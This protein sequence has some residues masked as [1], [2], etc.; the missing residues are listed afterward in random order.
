MADRLIAG[1]AADA[2]SETPWWR[3]WWRRWW[4]QVLAVVLVARVVTTGILLFFASNQAENAWT[5]ASPSYVD[6]AT[7]WDGHWYR[8]IAGW[9]YPTELPMTDDGHVGENAWAFMPVYPMVVRALMMLT[10]LDFAIVAVAVSVICSTVAAL[11]FFRLMVQFLPH[12]SALFAVA[13]FCMNPVAPILQLGYAEAMHAMLLTWALLLLTRRSYWAMAPIVVIMALTRPSGLAFA[14]AMALHVGHRWLT[15]RRDPYPAREIVASVAITGIAGVA[16]LAW[17][18]IAAGVTGSLTAYTD[19]ELAWRSAY[20]G[21]GELVPFTPWF[22][23]AVWWSEHL[24]VPAW[25]GIAVLVVA[26]LGAAAAIW[27]PW[28]RRLGPDIR[29]WVASWLLYLLAVFFP[30]SSTW[31]LLLPAFPALGALA[32]PRSPVFRGALIAA[33]LIGQVVWID[34]MWAVSATDWTPP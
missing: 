25:A 21:R 31:R 10:G 14:L 6:F 16:G 11:L 18:L 2:E 15:R 3:G 9:G 17:L 12:G 19:T 22:Q 26:I 7:I 8:I 34:G 30:Q 32:V 24:G 23:G 28:M 29:F 4:V 20:I 13:L 27:S 5:G 33:C 1:P